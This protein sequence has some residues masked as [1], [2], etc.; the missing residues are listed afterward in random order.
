MMLGNIKTVWEPSRPS[1]LHRFFKDRSAR[2]SVEQPI[3]DAQSDDA[4]HFDDGNQ[5]KQKD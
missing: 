3:S 4:L 1:V 5:L 2:C